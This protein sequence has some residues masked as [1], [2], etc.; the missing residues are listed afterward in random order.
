MKSRDP[1]SG[2]RLVCPR[3][4][5]V[6]EDGRLLVADLLDD[7]GHRPAALGALESSRA[8]ECASPT[9]RARYPVVAGIPVVFRS[10]DACALDTAAWLGPSAP[11]LETLEAA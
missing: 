5:R 7:A 2:L 9:C 6:A 4:R 10:P 1:L 8:L 3:C 11:G